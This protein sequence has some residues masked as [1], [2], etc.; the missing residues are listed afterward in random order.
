M[1]VICVR[2]PIP[3]GERSDNV[4]RPLGGGF[5]PLA[6]PSDRTERDDDT[7]HGTQFVVHQQ[8]D[9]GMSERKLTRRSV[10][11]GATA[12]GVIGSIG[13]G[14]VALLQDRVEFPDNEA[15]VGSMN[16]ELRTDENGWVD[17]ETVVIGYGDVEPGDSET[18]GIDLRVCE[19][20]GWVWLRTEPATSPLAEELQTRL[21]V[22]SDCN[23]EFDDGDESLYSGS[24][25]GLAT[26]LADGRK[27]LDEPLGCDDPTCL[28]F[29]WELPPED[30]IETA[31]EDTEGP[32]ASFSIEFA[33]QQ[34][35]HNPDPDNPWGQQ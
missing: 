2:E 16:L 31:I 1:Y 4:D 5:G 25:S 8:G 12:T 22:D 14:T 3:W 7:S 23:R 26:A 15:T 24:L 17:G 28:G 35:R 27:L 9:R 30:E 19:N 34:W 10:L 32:E 11:A 33:A 18:T 20:P 6:G 21:W 13:G 29:R